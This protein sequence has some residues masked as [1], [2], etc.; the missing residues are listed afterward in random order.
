MKSFRQFIEET[1]KEKENDGYFPV[2]VHGSHAKPKEK[3]KENDGYFPVVVHGSHAKPKKNIKENFDDGIFNEFGRRSVTE[4][5]NEEFSKHYDYLNKHPKKDYITDYTVSSSIINRNL[6]NERPMSQGDMNTVQGIDE[7]LKD[8]PPMD[9]DRV[10]FSGLG[11][12]PRRK[13][14]KN[15][16]LKSRA[17]ISS[18]T[19]GRVAHNFAHHLDSEGNFHMDTTQ[20]PIHTH[21]LQIRLPKGSKHGAHIQTVSDIPGESEFLFKRDTEFDIDPTPEVSVEDNYVHHI[22]HATPVTDE[23]NK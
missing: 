13:M 6:I 22:W 1:N 21:T 15:N 16:R 9:K 8:A 20:G 18:S 3:E 14:D 7:A 4:K 12:D 19:D 2:V 5:E 10:V 17:Y 11:F 23:K